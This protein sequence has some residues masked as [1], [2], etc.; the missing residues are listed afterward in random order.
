[1]LAGRI[2]CTNNVQTM[3]TLPSFLN[4]CAANHGFVVK[5][6]VSIKCR[7]YVR[8]VVVLLFLRPRYIAKVMSKRSVN[9]LTTLFLGRLRPLKRL[10]STSGGHIL[11]PVTEKLSFL[12]QRKE[13]WKFMAGPGI[14]SET[15]GY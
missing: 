7:R 4:Q 13:K 5:T 11:S 10:T 6:K 8:S 1:M 9:H 12:N 3:V 2:Y 15:S 14:Q